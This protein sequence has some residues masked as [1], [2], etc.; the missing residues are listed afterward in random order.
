MVTDVKPLQFRKANEPMDVT[1]SPSDSSFMD[2]LPENQLP[3]KGQ[4]MVTDV[5]PLQNSKA[6]SP[7]DVTLLPMF[8]VV[9]PLQPLNILI[10]IIGNLYVKR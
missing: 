6:P 1:L 3:T 5:K 8:T 4:R 10:L 9:R 2:V 7:I